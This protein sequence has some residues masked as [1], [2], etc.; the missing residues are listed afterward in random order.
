MQCSGPGYKTP[1]DAIK[2]PREKIV[3][4]TLVYCG[5]DPNHPDCL[6]TIDVD[7]NS[8][9]YSK[10]ISMLR[11]PYVGDEVHHFGW[12]TCSSCC[13]DVTKQ[14]RFIILPGL[15]SSRIYFIDVADERT[16]KIHKVIEPEVIKGKMNLSSPHTVHCLANGKLM[17]SMLGD[18]SGHTPGGFLLIDEHFEVE[19]RWGKHDTDGFNLNYDFWYQPYHN[20]MISSEWAAPTTFAD[21]F[22]PVDVAEGKYGRHLCFWNWKEETILKKVDL[23]DDGLI[24][25]ELRFHHDPKSPHG[26]VGAALGRYSEKP[27][28]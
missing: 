27:F 5:D 20:V 15:K 22:N 13:N 7:K 6:A 2:A 25:L 12:N 14:R 4:T 3:Y 24:P 23:G 1:Q 21:G 26:Y 10:V 19:R 17:L 8:S 18:G 9:T 11:L 16:P 28:F